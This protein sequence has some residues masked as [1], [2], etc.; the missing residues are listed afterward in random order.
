MPLYCMP[1]NHEPTRNLAGLPSR[2]DQWQTNLDVTGRLQVVGRGRRNAHVEEPPGVGP[3]QP[4]MGLFRRPIEP[5]AQSDVDTLKN[6][7]SPKRRA[8]WPVIAK[9]LGKSEESLKRKREELCR[10]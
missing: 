1:S 6:M 10:S 7:K 8:G 5:D 4:A 2:A 3:G 9:K